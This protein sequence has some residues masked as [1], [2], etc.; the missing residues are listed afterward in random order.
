LPKRTNKLRLGLLIF[1]STTIKFDVFSEKN[2][3]NLTG[4]HHINLQ[5]SDVKSLTEENRPAQSSLAQHGGLYRSNQCPVAVPVV[6]PTTQISSFRLRRLWLT[7]VPG[8]HTWWY[9][10]WLLI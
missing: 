1:F 3:L 5:Q 9:S 6:Q 8:P 10:I 7:A 4:K 2:F